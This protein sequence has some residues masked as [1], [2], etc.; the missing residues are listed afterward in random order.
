MYFHHW[1]SVWPLIMIPNFLLQDLVTGF[2]A[3]ITSLP[4]AVFKIISMQLLCWNPFILGKDRD[5]WEILASRSLLFFWLSDPP[6][7]R[8]STPLVI[9]SLFCSSAVENFLSSL[10]QYAL[11][12]RPR[13]GAATRTSYWANTSQ[14]SASYHGTHSWLISAPSSQVGLRWLPRLGAW[15]KFPCFLLYSAYDTLLSTLFISVGA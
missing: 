6:L 5:T 8:H 9:L 12:P 14:C 7:P 1:V 2:S 3:D 15:I 13:R 10:H 4:W 11:P